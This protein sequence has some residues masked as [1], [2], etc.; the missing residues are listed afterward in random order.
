MDSLHGV[1]PAISATAGCGADSR[2]E[3]KASAAEKAFTEE[4]T[5]EV[6]SLFCREHEMVV[7]GSCLILMDLD[8]ERFGLS[9][10]VDERFEG[11]VRDMAGG[12]GVSPLS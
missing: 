10:E 12:P 9:M 2:I 6:E 5:V 4:E 8:D 1:R 3:D 7:A 11:I